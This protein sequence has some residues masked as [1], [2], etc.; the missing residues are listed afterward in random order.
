M[1]VLKA[2]DQVLEPRTFLVGESITLADMAVATAVLLPFKYVCMLSVRFYRVANCLS[3]YICGCN[4]I[5]CTIIQSAASWLLSF[6]F[7]FLRHWS[8]QTG[9]S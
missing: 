3:A 9:K 6:F 4:N 8:H 1:R 5:Y 2:L 7:F